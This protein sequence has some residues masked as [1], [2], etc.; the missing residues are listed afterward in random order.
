MES[1]TLLSRLLFGAAIVMA[2]LASFETFA[3]IMKL[4]RALESV[5]FQ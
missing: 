1:G 5:M 2:V 3:V 4:S